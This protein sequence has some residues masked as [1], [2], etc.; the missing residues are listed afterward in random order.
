ML[1]TTNAA[2]AQSPETR[3]TLDEA[4]AQGLANSHRL[5]ELQARAD[6]ALA[7]EQGR[8]AARLPVVALQGGYMRTNHVE[9]FAVIAPG[10][11]RQIIYPDVPDNARSRLDLQWLVYSGGQLDALERA[12]RA[13]R[14]A[15]GDDL[16]AARAD[17]RLEVTRAFWALVTARDAEQ[18]L[19]RSLD[20]ITAYVGDLR[21]RLEQGLIPPNELLS[22]QAQQSRERVAS[23]EAANARHIAE[24]DLR[25]LTGIE[26]AG[27]IAPA[28]PLE[29]P[30]PAAPAD[31]AALIAAAIE[32]RPERRALVQ[33]AD[34]ARSRIDAARAAG[35]PQVGVAAGY[36]YARPNPRIFPRAGQWEDS[37]DV[38]INATWNLWDGGRVRAARA[39][40]TAGERAAEARLADFDRQVT[41]E[42]RQRALELESSVAA[43]S[44]AGDGVRA[45]AEAQRVLGERFAAGVA[46][47]TEV[48]DAQTALLQAELDRTR[49]LASA[50]VAQAR[51]DRAV[52]R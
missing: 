36:D 2:R 49:A 40:A 1:A 33:R 8:G 20:R 32:Q 37:W 41:F 25:R 21:A 10:P 5:A 44:A 45:A 26:G 11:T 43:I 29:A 52:G 12:A 24:A 35:L 51:L 4:I 50:R 6:A 3:L 7:N 28:S 30:P 22:A 42:V 9:E 47:N 16:A 39:E 18:V 48:L 13:E 38:S 17:L 19:A 27:A 46:T 15:S 23:I 34:A 14:E 31:T